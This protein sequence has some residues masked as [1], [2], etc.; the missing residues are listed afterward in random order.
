M[1]PERKA[2]QVAVDKQLIEAI[3]KREDK[4]MMFG[5]LKLDFKLSNHQLPHKMVF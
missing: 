2:D 5:Y 3:K 4:K 1:T